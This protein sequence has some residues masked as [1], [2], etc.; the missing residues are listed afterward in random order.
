M[1]DAQS[2]LRSL[3]PLLTA[4]GN[5]DPSDPGAREVLQTRFPLDHPTLRDVRSHIDLGLQEGWLCPREA[6]GIRF[7]RLTK[8][9]ED[10]HDLSVDAVEMAGPGPGHTH[11]A[12][13]FDLCFA[14]DG[15]PRFEGEPAGWVVLPPGSWHVPTVTGGR[16]AILY[17][18]PQGAIE[19]GPR[20]T[21]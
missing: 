4:I 18:L 7:G 8:A 3:Q 17:F 1:S 2:L 16:M 20:P 19:F 13:E 10:S 12:G 5:L 15:D 14:L 6:G 21:G 9:T 11:P